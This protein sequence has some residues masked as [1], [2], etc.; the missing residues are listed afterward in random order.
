MFG[1]GEVE[2]FGR[3]WWMWLGEKS[4]R[5]SVDALMKFT[6]CFAV[7]RILSEQLCLVS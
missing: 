1:F 2:L 5:M 3:L 4:M 7:I 6:F